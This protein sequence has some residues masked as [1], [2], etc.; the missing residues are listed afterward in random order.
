MNHFKNAVVIITGG[1]SGIG[2]SIAQQLDEL[3]ARIVVADRV[4]KPRDLSYDYYRV[5]MTNENEVEQLFASVTV[6]V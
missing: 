2:A 5:D 4:Q 1:A 3:G 6:K